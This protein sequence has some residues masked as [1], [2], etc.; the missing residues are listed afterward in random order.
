MGSK[1]SDEAREFVEK[2]EP[3]CG[4]SR[5]LK[6]CCKIIRKLIEDNDLLQESYD[7]MTQEIIRLNNELFDRK[8]GVQSD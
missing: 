8:R 5:I 1:V 2:L 6:E 4:D 3:V 7:R